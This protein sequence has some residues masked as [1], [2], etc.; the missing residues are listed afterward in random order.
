MHFKDVITPGLFKSMPCHTAKFVDETLVSKA[1]T[2]MDGKAPEIV[3]AEVDV[4]KIA[5]PT[6][7]GGPIPI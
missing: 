3:N 1:G 2:L 5:S 4:F 7:V 6:F